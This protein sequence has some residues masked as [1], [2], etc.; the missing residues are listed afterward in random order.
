MPAGISRLTE[1]IA[2]S[3]KKYF[4]DANVWIFALGN[5]PSSNS[6]G[7]E[8]IDFL[9]S[10][11]ASEMKIYSHTILISEVFNAL[12]RITF[13]DFVKIKEHQAGKRLHFDYKKDFRHTEEYLQAF[14]RFQSDIEA[15]LPFIHIIDKEYEYEMSYLIKNLPSTSD[16]NDYLY[17]EM[18]LDLG[19]VIVTD[20][21]DFDYE[22]IEILTEN[23]ELLKK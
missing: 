1:E 21:G 3:D 19:L 16:F 9:D 20:D 17:Y 13:R 18:A 14:K 7:Q 5:P 22:G 15:Y 23:K 4:L 6:N 8:Y 10:L 2:S 11:L 12:M